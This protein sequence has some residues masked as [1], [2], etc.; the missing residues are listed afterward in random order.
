MEEF[1]CSADF[2]WAKEVKCLLNPS[3]YWHLPLSR[4]GTVGFFVV[5][6]IRR[7]CFEGW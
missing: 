1:Y 2:S 4:G 5:F 7:E 6:W 3:A